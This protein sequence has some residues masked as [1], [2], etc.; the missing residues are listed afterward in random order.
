MSH[1]ARLLARS[2]HFLATRLASARH[3]IPA[4]RTLATLTPTPPRVDHGQ[5]HDNQ[6]VAAMG[7]T[8]SGKDLKIRKYPNFE[9]KEDERLYR[10]QH[11]AAAYRVFAE[12]GFDEGVAGHISVR[13]PVME[14]HFCEYFVVVCFISS[15]ILLYLP[16]CF[17]SRISICLKLED[18]DQHTQGSTLSPHTSPKSACQT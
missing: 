10:K 16:S 5:S 17:W 15:V 14:D 4:L 7:R 11:L 18:A 13:D 12:R 8:A 2:P 6:T 9:R 1:T 3:V